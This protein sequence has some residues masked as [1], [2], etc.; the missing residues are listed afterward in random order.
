MSDPSVADA[1][2]PPK[3]GWYD[4]PTTPGRDRW[5]SGYE[6]TEHTAR[7]PRPSMFGPGYERAGRARPNRPAAIGQWLPLGA[8]G[9][10]VVVSF[11]SFALPE[12]FPRGVL[13]SLVV[14]QCLLG[15]VAVVLGITGLSRT[16]RWGGLQASISTIVGGSIALII[17]IVPVA[18]ALV[19]G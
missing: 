10:F 13:A 15:L 7:S 6:W 3:R 11:G 5:W 19:T 1:G 8:M 9:L 17:V 16:R 12:A 14:L 2:L 4:D 18:L